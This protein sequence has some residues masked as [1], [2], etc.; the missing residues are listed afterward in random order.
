MSH[1]IIGCIDQVIQALARLLGQKDSESGGGL[2]DH[3]CAVLSRIRGPY[4][5]VYWHS[6]TETLW[7]GRDYFGRRSLVVRGL[8]RHEALVLA[9][10][11]SG[12]C[13]VEGGGEWLEV[14]A[15]GVYSISFA[16]GARGPIALRPWQ[17]DV[18][19]APRDEQPRSI[20]DTIVSSSGPVSPITPL[21]KSLPCTADLPERLEL[22]EP[23]AAF[24]RVFRQAI[25]RRVLFQCIS[26]SGHTTTPRC[27]VLFSVC[28]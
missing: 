11:T 27:A 4:A 10:V 17:R 25:E 1:G 28:A 24:L 3:I 14:P 8:H 20:H 2:D 7:F 5:F 26:A 19:E 21:C 13:D 9:S 22:D 15:K 18:H 12:Q 23:A 16:H 6:A